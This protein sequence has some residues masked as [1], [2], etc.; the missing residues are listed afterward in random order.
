MVRSPVTCQK[1]DKTS[2]INVMS[3]SGEL[4]KTYTTMLYIVD[5]HIEYKVCKY[6]ILK[7]QWA[8]GITGPT[9]T[10]NQ[11]TDEADQLT[12]EEDNIKLLIVIV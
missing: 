10:W 12:E 2:W 4:L 11:N 9:G 1:Q 5:W 6:C 8:W 3:Q 7:G